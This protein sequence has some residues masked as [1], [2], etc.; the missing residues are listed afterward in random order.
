MLMSRQHFEGQV[1][2]LKRE[3]PEKFDT[4]IEFTRGDIDNCLVE[5]TDKNEDIENT[6]QNLSIDFREIEKELLEIKVK[7]EVIVSPLRD[8]I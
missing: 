7:Q 6:L 2:G 4:M 8:Y 3:S 1:E 5:Y